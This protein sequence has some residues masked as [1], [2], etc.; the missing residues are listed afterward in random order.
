MFGLCKLISCLTQIP[1][2]LLASSHDFQDTTAYV[3]IYK[4]KVMAVLQKTYNCSDLTISYLLQ[5][6]NS[7][8]SL[9]NSNLP[10]LLNGPAVESSTTPWTRGAATA[11]L[12]GAPLPPLRLD[13]A[14]RQLPP[15]R[16]T[17]PAQTCWDTPYSE[18]MITGAWRF[19]STPYLA[20]GRRTA[21]WGL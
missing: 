12:P 7:Q 20:S 8:F 19:V 11:H 9:D 14:R 5:T 17:R 1:P 6:L 21:P 4:A 15:S 10:P 13:T 18:I 2:P 16:G 3:C